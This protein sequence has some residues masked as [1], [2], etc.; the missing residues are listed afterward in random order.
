MNEN[1]QMMNYSEDRIT[2]SSYQLRGKSKYGF[3]D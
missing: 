3:F 2:I 1:A